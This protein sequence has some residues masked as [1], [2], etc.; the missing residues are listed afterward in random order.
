MLKD[1]DTVVQEL[2]TPHHI[3][4]Q[5]WRLLNAR[6]GQLLLSEQYLATTLDI[7]QMEDILWLK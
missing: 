1:L 3:R 4:P 6:L 7:H 2:K 5:N